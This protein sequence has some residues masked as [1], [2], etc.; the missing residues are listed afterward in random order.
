[1]TAPVQYGGMGLDPL[2]YVVA[3]EEIARYDGSIA[4]TL[5]SHNTLACGHLKRSGTDEQKQR[6]LPLMASGKC[7]GAW[8]LSE[9]QT[10]SD[11]ASIR[12]TAQR[13]GDHWILRGSKMF[14][15]QGSVAGLYIIMARTGT[16][17]KRHHGISA[18]LVEAGTKG[19]QIG[20]KLKKMGCRGSDT[21]SLVLKDVGVP[22]GALLGQ[23]G[24]A[25]ADI[26]GLLDQGRTG[27]A[28]MAVGIARGCLEEA[29]SYARKRKQF[30]Q[31]IGKTQAIQWMLA[32][33]A[34]EIDAARMLVWRAAEK[35]H[36]AEPCTRESAMAKLFASEV[37][38]RAAN[39]AL[40]IHGGYGYLRDFP[41]ER[42]LR[43]AKACELGEGTSEMQRLV[44]ARDLLG[45]LA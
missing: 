30:D 21:T 16:G 15:T 39:V 1:M 14:V 35:I 9:S 36:A 19:L 18:F 40:Q 5:T 34:T 27:I 38:T 26:M 3:L 33:M 24:N 6:Y 32:D 22:A 2:S 42:Y 44:I 37:A 12:T 11:A 45:R 7:L 43:D 20:Q 41:V 29:V 17:D 10:G 25:F 4:L 28:A 8:A 13:K 31:P 23:E